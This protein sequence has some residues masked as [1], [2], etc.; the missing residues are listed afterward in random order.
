MGN[1]YLVRNYCHH[2]QKIESKCPQDYEFEA[3][4]VPPG[5]E[6]LLGPRELIV[7]ERR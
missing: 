7:F 3:F 1:P 4:E 6:V 2:E 5:D